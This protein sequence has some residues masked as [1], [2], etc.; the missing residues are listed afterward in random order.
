MPS[1]CSLVPR[2]APRRCAQMKQVTMPNLQRPFLLCGLA[3]FLPSSRPGERE[4]E[5]GLPRPLSFPW[6]HAALPGKWLQLQWLQC[7]ANG[8]NLCL[9]RVPTPTNLAL[10]QD[11]GR[12][13]SRWP[14]IGVI[15]CHRVLG[16]S[17]PP[18]ILARSPPPSLSLHPSLAREFPLP[19]P[20]PFLTRAPLPPRF[21]RL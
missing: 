9:A 12:R 11:L 18:S 19:P 4:R 17:P 7:Q 5:G 1:P 3:V 21:L 6:R 20:L 16:P 2:D 14:G 8:S 15:G 10:P 13:W